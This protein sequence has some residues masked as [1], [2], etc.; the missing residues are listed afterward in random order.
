MVLQ[1]GI[2]TLEDLKNELKFA[3]KLIGG[4]LKGDAHKYATKLKDALDFAVQTIER[5]NMQI[6]SLHQTELM[7]KELQKELA[8]FQQIHRELDEKN[9]LLE[10]QLSSINERVKKYGNLNNLLKTKS[11][12][13]NKAKA[14][15][16]ALRSEL[17]DTRLNCEHEI[18]LAY[19]N[20]NRRVEENSPLSDTV[21]TALKITIIIAVVIGLIVGLKY[22]NDLFSPLIKDAISTLIP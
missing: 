19:S 10:K 6:R 5:Y 20:A 7:N 13:L 12:E 21:K 14:E 1:I 3:R 18:D 9:M 11:E 16:E 4:E 15:I 8:E 22:A 17:K 2:T